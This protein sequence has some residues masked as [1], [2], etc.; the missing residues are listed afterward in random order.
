MD[1]EEDKKVREKV[2]EKK[3]EGK[4]SDR[5]ERKDQGKIRLSLTLN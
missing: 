5:M 4:E 1:S 2:Q 3:R